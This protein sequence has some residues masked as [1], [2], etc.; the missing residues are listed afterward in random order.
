MTILLGQSS[1]HIVPQLCVA[2]LCEVQGCSSDACLSICTSCGLKH[3]SGFVF[4]HCPCVP[5]V[6]LGSET[7]VA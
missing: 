6:Q 1:L 3:P 7:M 2:F 5:R 4:I